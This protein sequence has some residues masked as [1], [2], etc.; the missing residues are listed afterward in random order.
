MVD[1][2]PRIGGDKRE[3][4]SA[5]TRAGMMDKTEWRWDGI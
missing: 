2:D 1:G 5:Q 4:A 3:R